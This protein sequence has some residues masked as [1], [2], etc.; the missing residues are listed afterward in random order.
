MTETNNHMLQAAFAEYREKTGWQGLSGEDAIESFVAFCESGQSKAYAPSPATD[1][2]G[3][4]VLARNGEDALLFTSPTSPT[5]YVIACGYDEATGEWA[6]GLYRS[7]LGRAWDEFQPDIIEQ[8]TVRWQRQDLEQALMAADIPPTRENVNDLLSATE[9]MRGWEDVAI[10]NGNEMLAEYAA[11]MKPEAQEATLCRSYGSLDKAADIVYPGGTDQGFV[12]KDARAFQ[13]KSGEICYIPEH[14]FDS[15]TPVD[16]G[17][18]LSECDG[19][20]YGQ[21][22]A[23]CGGNERVAEVVFQNVDWQGPAAY[24]GEMDEEELAELLAQERGDGGT[25]YSLGSEQ[26]DMN[27]ARG[28]LDTGS[29]PQPGKER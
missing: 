25:L 9:Y 3:R 7:D 22:L 16:G 6:S 26:R 12:Y 14:G 21:F 28:A 17:Y 8:A 23:A 27:A 11:G 1:P 19:Y 24:Y 4:T 29:A 15:A 2:K 10:Q 5:P 20:T 18:R 13:E